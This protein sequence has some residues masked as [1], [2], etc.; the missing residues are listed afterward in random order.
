MVGK[1]RVDFLETVL[2]QLRG[3]AVR[4][5]CRTVQGRAWPPTPSRWLPGWPDATDRAVRDPSQRNMI[6]SP[7]HP[8]LRVLVT[9][10]APARWS[11][12]RPVFGYGRGQRLG[13]WL[14]ASAS[15]WGQ[16]GDRRMATRRR[17][18]GGMEG[19]SARWTGLAFGQT[20]PATQQHGAA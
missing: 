9:A 20:A 3:D 1:G 6:R 16:R 18:E 14:Q 13:L 15:F 7:N 17:A 8:P 10:S 19:C 12:S 4:T 5:G 2:A 11:S